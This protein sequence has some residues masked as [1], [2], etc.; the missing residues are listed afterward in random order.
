MKDLKPVIAKLGGN[1][2]F[3]RILAGAPDTAGIKSGYVVLQPGESVGEH[4]TR[5]REEAIIILDGCAQ[6]YCAGELLFCAQPDSLVYIPPQTR[7][8]IKNTADKPLRYVY[9]V[10][11]VKE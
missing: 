3:K 9:V 11:P 5:G 10:S 6:V 8:D 2:K 1:E 4:E 7:H